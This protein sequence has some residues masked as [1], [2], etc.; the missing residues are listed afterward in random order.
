MKLIAQYAGQKR[1]IRNLF[2]QKAQ[3]TGGSKE[4]RKENSK[5]SDH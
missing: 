4:I 3:K 5:L 2:G 1:L